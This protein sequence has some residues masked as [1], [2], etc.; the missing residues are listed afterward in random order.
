MG[1]TF[2]KEDIQKFMSEFQDESLIRLKRIIKNMDISGQSKDELLQT[3]LAYKEYKKGEP[4]QKKQ[5]KKLSGKQLNGIVAELMEHEPETALRLLDMHKLSP[6]DREKV[7]G[8]YV[9]EYIKYSKKNNLPISP[10]IKN[11]RR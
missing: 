6:A 5:Q 9:K 10:L 11:Y 7:M 1:K 8:K 2:S 3:V 4:K